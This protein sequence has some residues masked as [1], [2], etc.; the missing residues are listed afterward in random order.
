M[1]VVLTSHC[2][3]RP[4]AS[5]ASSYLLIS[6]FLNAESQRSLYCFFCSLFLLKFYLHLLSP[7]NLT[8]PSWK[9]SLGVPISSP[10]NVAGLNLWR[11][12][13]TQPYH[14]WTWQSQLLYLV[15]P[16]S[17]KKLTDP[18]I[19]HEHPILTH[20]GSQHSSFLLETFFLE[21]SYP[22]RA[23]LELSLPWYSCAVIHVVVQCALTLYLINYT[24][25]LIKILHSNKSITNWTHLKQN[26]HL[27]CAGR[28]LSKLKPR[29]AHLKCYQKTSLSK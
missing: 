8:I 6:P 3:K 11:P 28:T 7:Q 22:S 25:D 24:N 16:E 26:M 21:S 29:L 19:S 10:T 5:F 9:S 1:W 18:T 15:S 17:T 13:N 2:L 12:F 23:N 20:T 14:K 27:M 4:L